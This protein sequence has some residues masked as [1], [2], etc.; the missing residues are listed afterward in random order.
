MLLLVLTGCVPPAV[1]FPPPT[2]H[3]TELVPVDQGVV[4][5]SG[6]VG[7]IAMFGDDSAA[8]VD[9]FG[10]IINAGAGYGLPA[11]FDLALQGSVNY[12]GPELGL[13]AGWTASGDGLVKHGPFIGLGLNHQ[14]F[15][16]DYTVAEG[17]D[18]EDTVHYD[19]QY[20]NLAPYLGY[21]VLV[22]VGKV[23]EVPV[24]V[25]MSDS[26]VLGMSGEEAP[27]SGA[28]FLYGEFQS[29]VLLKGGPMRY[30][31]DVGATFIGSSDASFTPE[32]IFR[33]GF[34]VRGD[35]R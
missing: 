6:G 28:D 29:G 27:E 35:I 16:G 11:N 4:A 31:L 24:G 23:V 26:L 33:F 9:L 5:I 14:H 1:H 34:S 7:G 21:R 15:Q 12:Y 3:G 13:Q 20:W 2:L 17:T 18:E 19:Y 8:S 30:G 22:P 25:R 32:P 10:G